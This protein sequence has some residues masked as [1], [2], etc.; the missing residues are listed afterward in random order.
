MSDNRILSQEEINALLSGA[1][2][3][4]EPEAPET[5]YNDLLT[6]LEKDALGEIGNIS[7]GNAATSLAVLLGQEVDITTPFI[8]VIPF[9]ELKERFPRPH[10]TINVDYTDGFE[11]MNLLVLKEDDAKVIANLMMGG[12]GTI[13]EVELSDL[14]ISAVQEAMNQMMGSAA[15]SMS[16][17]F[18]RFV[19][20]TPPSIQILD[21]TSG[22]NPGFSE[23]II[24]GISFRL[25]IGT[26]V[27]SN[28]MQLVPLSFARNMVNI[29]MG[30][31]IEDTVGTQEEPEP[32]ALPEQQPSHQSEVE[33][34]RSSVVEE[35][36]QEPKIPSQPSMPE[37]MSPFAF[38][39]FSEE[40]ASVTVND[41]N[42]KLLMDIPLQ[43]SVELG[44]ASKRVDEIL[45]LSD[46][47]IV[48]LDRLSGEPVDILVNNKLIAKGEV[49]VID[50][51][52]AVRLTEIINPN[53]RLKSMR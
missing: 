47:S 28:I 8:E 50:E 5:D 27:D 1:S 31:T 42:L 14:H 41:L 46:G 33:K 26:F 35:K 3:S 15:T 45:D 7:L 30:G 11:G 21:L 2:T 20:I 10:V 32:M 37:S 6:P 36:K 51:N 23:E 9:T 16:T 18:N 4:E 49:V 44:R 24:V 12:D 52:F 53:E 34:P 22:K 38:P 40:P 48:E 17:L 43:V 39:S 25:T 19:N 13:D 29:L